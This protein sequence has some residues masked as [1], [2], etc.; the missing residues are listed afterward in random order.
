M[1]QQHKHQNEVKSTR[2]TGK[3]PQWWQQYCR[4]L[5]HTMYLK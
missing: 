3:R 4:L 1:E 2:L 5:R